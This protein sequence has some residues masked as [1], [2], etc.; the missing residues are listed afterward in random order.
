MR[1]GHDEIG[2]QYAAVAAQRGTCLRRNVGCCLTNERNQVLATGYNGRASGL[3]HCKDTGGQHDYACAGSKAASG[4]QLDAC[5]A[6]HAE[7]NALLQCHDVY[8]IETCYVTVSPCVTCVKM[9][10]NT[11]CGRIVFKEKY[12]HDE[13]A[14]A[15]WTKTGR[16][17]I[18]G[19]SK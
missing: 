8:A 11:S 15:L 17:W 7:Q 3:P 9:L 19:G 14:K 2:L 5:E 6:I 12:S 18:E 4:T 13:A 16:K 10:M 1:P